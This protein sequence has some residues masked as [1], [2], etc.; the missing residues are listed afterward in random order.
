LIRYSGPSAQG[1]HQG[2]GQDRRKKKAHHVTVLRSEALRQGF[3]RA[4]T[5]RHRSLPAWVFYDGMSDD[6]PTGP[7]DGALGLLAPQGGV[8]G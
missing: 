2:N 4:E 3:P 7:L 8:A 1:S 5:G 6:L